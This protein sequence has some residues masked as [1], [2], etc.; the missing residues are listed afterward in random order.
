MSGWDR[1]LYYLMMFMY[2]ALIALVLLNLGTGGINDPADLY[3]WILLTLI[4]ALAISG[5]VVAEKAERVARK[6]RR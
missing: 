1:A 6:K 3:N 2:L 5:I 4:V